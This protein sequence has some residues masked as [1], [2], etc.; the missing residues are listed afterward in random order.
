MR[1][2]G[3]S[4]FTNRKKKSE[5]KEKEDEKAWEWAQKRNKQGLWRGWRNRSW[6]YKRMLMSQGAGLWCDGRLIWQRDLL[7]AQESAALWDWPASVQCI[8]CVCLCVCSERTGGRG[9]R[10]KEVNVSSLK[11]YPFS[12]LW[13][14]QQHLAHDFSLIFPHHKEKGGLHLWERGV[15]VP[16]I[17]YDLSKTRR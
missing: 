15:M 11:I 7:T 1:I 2:V 12:Y 9:E 13:N 17:M 4:R 14:S 3:W 6:C 10:Q 5:S 8:L 16:L